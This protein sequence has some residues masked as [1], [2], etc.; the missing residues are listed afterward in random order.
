MHPKSHKQY[1]SKYRVYLTGRWTS[2]IISE[3]YRTNDYNDALFKAR[4]LDAKCAELVQN[5]AAFVKIEVA[6]G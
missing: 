1:N 6:N 3:V 5:F 2:L 4:C